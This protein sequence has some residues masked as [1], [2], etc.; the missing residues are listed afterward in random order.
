MITGQMLIA[1]LH[2]LSTGF[3]DRAINVALTAEDI[4][5]DLRQAMASAISDHK[6]PAEQAQGRRRR[7]ARRA[8]PTSS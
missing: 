2:G 8:R 1:L 5:D 7:A 3:P 6:V 4:D